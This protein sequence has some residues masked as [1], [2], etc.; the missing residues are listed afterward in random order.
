MITDGY[1]LV[2][3][4]RCPM[5][6]GATLI[7]GEGGFVTCGLPDCPRPDAVSVLL[8]DPEPEHLVQLGEDGF[9]IQHP[10]RERIDA[11]LLRCALHDYLAEWAGPQA[12]PGLYRVS[13]RGNVVTWGERVGA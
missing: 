8:A 7:L 1:A 5:G 2:V 12:P 13:L 11:E 3:A 4:G 10:L 6:C 9:A